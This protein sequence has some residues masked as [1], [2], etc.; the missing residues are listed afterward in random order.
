MPTTTVDADALLG[1]LSLV[2]EAGEVLA[3][4][5]RTHLA[6]ATRRRLVGVSQ[7][8]AASADVLLFDAA[9]AWTETAQALEFDLPALA[10]AVR[11][12]GF[13]AVLA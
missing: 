4:S 13:P 1:R 2:L 11:A 9:D 6:A 3:E 7:E 5:V 8:P 12:A 10:A